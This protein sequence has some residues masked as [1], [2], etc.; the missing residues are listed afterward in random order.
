MVTDIVCHEAIQNWCPCTNM[1]EKLGIRLLSCDM[2]GNI[3]SFLIIFF[4]KM[5]LRLNGT[6]AW[7]CD[8]LFSSTFTS[9]ENY[10]FY[11]TTYP[12]TDSSDKLGEVEDQ[13][14]ICLYLNKR[15][16]PQSITLLDKHSQKAHL[17]RFK[18]IQKLS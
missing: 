10:L 6:L 14:L 11:V 5:K 4:T 12:L 15:G 9:F 3:K 7:I 13:K 8:C 17:K 18:F 2:F 1:G 16:Y